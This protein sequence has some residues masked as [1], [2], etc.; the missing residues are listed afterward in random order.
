M[1]LALFGKKWPKPSG[2]P[3]EPRLFP[4]CRH[5]VFPAPEV[6]RSSWSLDRRPNYAVVQFTERGLI[7]QRVPTVARAA[8]AFPEIGSVETATCSYHPVP[9]VCMYA[10]LYVCICIYLYVC[11]YVCDIYLFIIF[12][13]RLIRKIIHRLA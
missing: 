9:Y 11:V 1:F 7:S 5:A 6:I 2:H 12:L 10:Y 4:W 8:R 3:A 13:F